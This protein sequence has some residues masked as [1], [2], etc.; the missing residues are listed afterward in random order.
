MGRT[1]ALA[2]RAERRRFSGA[3]DRVLETTLEAA[4]AALLVAMVVLAFVQVV[5]RFVFNDPLSWS[6][7]VARWCFVWMTFLGAALG[8]KRNAHVAI[9]NLVLALPPAGQKALRLLGS[10][11]VAVV[12]SALVVHGWALV[13][14][15]ILTSAALQWPFKYLFLSMPVGG[16]LM[17]VYVAGRRVLGERDWVSGPGV[18]ALAALVYHLAFSAK[19]V[20]L[21][22]I[23]P[24]VTLVAVLLLMLVLGV[25]IA[26]SVGL[27]A[28]LA[29]AVKGTI[30]LLTFPQFMTGGV[31][32]FPLLAVPFFILAGELMNVGGITERIYRFAGSLVGHF[33]GGLAQVNVVTSTFIAGLSGSATADAA[34]DSKMLVPVMV[35]HGYGRAFACSITAASATIAPIIPPSIG[36]VIYGATANVSIGRLFLGGYVPGLLMTG[37]LMLT[38]YLISRKRGYGAGRRASA[39][40]ALQA[41]RGAVLAILMP[42]IIVGGIRFGI[43]T[44]TEA[45]SVAVVYAAVVIVLV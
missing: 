2:P 41:L 30:P 9:D 27:A 19:V 39:G 11:V 20:P 24:G 16:A 10:F 28:L 21:P 17:L 13:Q 33:R 6:E 15:S 18:V 43:F 38:V 29:M 1:E 26:F 4:I 45:A 36:L 14:D 8:V 42:F 3:V 23:S 25:P 40:E 32:S 7:E 31:D 22:P 5:L 12:S 34:A 35:Q 44:P 37:A